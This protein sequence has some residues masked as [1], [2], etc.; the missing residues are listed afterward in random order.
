[1]DPN[2]QKLETKENYQTQS[3][4]SND[5]EYQIYVICAQSL[6]W[7]FKTYDEWLNS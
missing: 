6:G 4:G 3:R 2:N 7:K 1:M 5:D